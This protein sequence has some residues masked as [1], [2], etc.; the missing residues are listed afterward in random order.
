VTATYS[1]W[2][3]RLK[4]LVGGKTSLFLVSDRVGKEYDYFAKKIIR[5]YGSSC[6]IMFNP[7][8]VIKNLD[9]NNQ[10]YLMI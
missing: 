4:P 6:A 2:I 1:Y 7:T 3:H 8:K 9:A 10:G 5:F